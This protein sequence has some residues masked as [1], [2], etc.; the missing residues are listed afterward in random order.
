MNSLRGNMRIF[1][2]I[3]TFIVTN[4]IIKLLLNLR[5]NTT[6]IRYNIIMVSLNESSEI[7][8]LLIYNDSN[9]VRT[10]NIRI[11]FIVNANYIKE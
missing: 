9:E 11:L 8:Y 10:I 5:Q 2:M 6:T 4:K 7:I 1:T 3:F